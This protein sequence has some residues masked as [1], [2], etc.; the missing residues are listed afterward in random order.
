MYSV[1]PLPKNNL[2]E[3]CEQKCL[4]RNCARQN[5]LECVKECI[6]CQSCSGYIPKQKSNLGKGEE[7]DEVSKA[8]EK[9]N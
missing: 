6:P 9:G 4:C 5:C 8:S 2:S 3:V 7:E 1:T